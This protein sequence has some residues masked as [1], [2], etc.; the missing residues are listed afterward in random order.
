VQKLGILAVA[1]VLSNFLVGCL[2]QS[3]FQAIPQAKTAYPWHDGSNG[4][5]YGI[6]E[7]WSIDASASEFYTVTETT[8]IGGSGH[9][10]S[11][12]HTVP[13]VYGWVEDT[14]IVGPQE[15]P[16]MEL[17]FISMPATYEKVMETRVIE[18]AT[19]EYDLIPPVFYADKSLKTPA[20][21]EKRYKKAVTRQIETLANYTPG[22]KVVE[23]LMPIEFR[24]GYRRVIIEPAKVRSVDETP[25]PIVRTRRV[26]NTPATL[27]IYNPEGDLVFT[28]DSFENFQ[29]FTKS[30][31]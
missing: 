13:P 24:E 27:N 23:R 31:K 28:F 3:S 15:E 26:L 1:L 17:V 21:F 6:G 11:V 12:L 20:K 14:S 10:A 9:F 18:P 4:G 30:L 7:G 25:E 16:E 22:G 19:I 8:T 29:T 2:H 5:L